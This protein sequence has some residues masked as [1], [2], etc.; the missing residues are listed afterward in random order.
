MTTRDEYVSRI[1]LVLMTQ[2][3]DAT[4]GQLAQWAHETADVVIAYGQTHPVGL[5]DPAQINPCG[6]LDDG[7]PSA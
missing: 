3:P 5:A 6:L 2:H 7:S 4:L 1:L